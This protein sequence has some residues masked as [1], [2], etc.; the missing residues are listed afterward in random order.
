MAKFFSVAP[1]FPSHFY[2]DIN[3][4]PETAY[5]LSTTFDWHAA[6][7]KDWSIQ[8]M[9]YVSHIENYIDKNK[10]TLESGGSESK[11][12]EEQTQELIAHITEHTYTKQIEIIAY[13]QKTYQVSLTVPGMNKWLKRHGF[14]Y[15]KPK[16]MPYKADLEKQAAFIGEYQKLKDSIS[17]KMDFNVKSFSLVK[18]SSTVILLLAYLS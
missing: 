4:K 14:S 10:L 9:P 18:F 3:L 8:V 7:N 13:I 17:E 12:D 11:L 2:G 15:K 1:A 6:N 5:T 16:S